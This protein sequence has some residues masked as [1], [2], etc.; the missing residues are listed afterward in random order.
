[1]TLVKRNSGYAP[2]FSNFFD[3]FLTRDLFDNNW[4]STSLTGTTIPKVN[5][6][7]SDDEFRVEM[8]APGMNKDDF[9]VELNNNVL[10]ISSEVSKED[11]ENS[12]NYSRREFSYQSFERSFNLP[13]SA[14]MEKIQ[15]KYTNGILNLVIPK[16]EEAK[17]KPVRTIK[18]S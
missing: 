10:T 13:D 2:L 6:E 7:E 12:S 14:E 9:R 17:T 1:M 4:L 16:R 8:A 5:I 11:D 18:I 15:A 3:D